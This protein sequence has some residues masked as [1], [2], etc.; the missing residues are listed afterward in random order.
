MNR[1]IFF[2]LLNFIKNGNDDKCIKFMQQYPDILYNNY[3]DRKTGNTLLIYAC[4]YNCFKTIKFLIQQ[5]IN[6][7]VVN[8]YGTTALMNLLG[9]IAEDTPRNSRIVFSNDTIEQLASDLINTGN[10]NLD[11]VDE[12]YGMSALKLAI[13]NYHPTIALKILNTSR[14]TDLDITYINETLLDIAEKKGFT[15]VVELIKKIMYENTPRININANCYSLEENETQPITDFITKSKNNVVFIII[16][17]D[18]NGK[19]ITTNPTIIGINKEIILKLNLNQ[20][21][22]NIIYECIESGSLRTENII[23]DKKYFNIKSILGFADIMLFEAID[24][25]QDIFYI[26]STH[27]GVSN[28]YSR[29]FC[30]IETKKKLISTVSEQNLSSSANFVSSR[31]CQEGQGATV[32]RLAVPIPY[33]GNKEAYETKEDETKEEYDGIET[34]K[35]SKLTA[36]VLL[37]GVKQIFDINPNTTITDLKETIYKQLEKTPETLRVRLM[38]KGKLLNDTDIVTQ[39]IM[40]EDVINAFTS[41]IGGRTLKR[42]RT[43][44]FSKKR[45]K[46]Y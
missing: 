12:E 10:S 23:R 34:K 2:R 4:K 44:K 16:N 19:Y 15:E 43:N 1:E 27:E 22:N 32:Y 21:K 20:E 25:L 41:K 38:Y 9:S 36:N 24:D 17:L 29:F 5:N 26:D 30:L 18:S 42:R 39:V 7:D 6:L 31:H 37:N 11:Y 13:L 40:P 8:N 46:N 28:L 3:I 33:C 35:E 45:R 14:I